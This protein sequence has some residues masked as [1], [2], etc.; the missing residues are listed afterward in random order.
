MALESR[1]HERE[2]HADSPCHD[3][4]RQHLLAVCSYMYQLVWYGI[5][6][7]IRPP[8]RPPELLAHGVARYANV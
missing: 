1:S 3:R 4:A 8:S 6:D 2:S 7:F 5:V